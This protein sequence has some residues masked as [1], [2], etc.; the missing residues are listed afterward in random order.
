MR[1]GTD[2]MKKD[3]LANIEET[4]EF[5]INIV[6]EEFIEEMNICAGE[7]PSETDELEI[8][9]L[10]KTNSKSISVP[11]VTESKVHLECKLEQVLHF[12]EHKGA[13]SLVIGK[14]IHVHVA[15]ELYENG[16]IDTE[17]LK[18]VGRLAGQMYTKPLADVFEL[19]RKMD[20]R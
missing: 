13:G 5:V 9:G 4:K 10:N 8:A 19:V 20:P 7:F 12:G 14:V 3:T 11:R 18:P 16:R 17:K 6:S 2:G 15:D 1:R